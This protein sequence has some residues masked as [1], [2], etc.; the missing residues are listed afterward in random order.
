MTVSNSRS[1][2]HLVKGWKYP[3]KVIRSAPTLKA[4]LILN[5]IAQ[6]YSK[7][8]SPS[9]PNAEQAHPQAHSF[10]SKRK[11]SKRLTDCFHCCL[12]VN[13]IQLLGKKTMLILIRGNAKNVLLLNPT[14]AWVNHSP[15]LTDQ[16]SELGDGDSRPRPSTTPSGHQHRLC[17]HLTAVNSCHRPLLPSSTRG[18]NTAT[19]TWWC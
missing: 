17:L 1:Y 16:D 18:W 4:K 11:I 2:R 5:C 9:I 6:D 15:S 7:T 3:L 13:S 12:D 10:T 8:S 14:L 19:T